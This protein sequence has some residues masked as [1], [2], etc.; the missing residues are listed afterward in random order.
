M[1]LAQSSPGKFRDPGA[2]QRSIN[3]DYTPVGCCTTYYLVYVFQ[4][5]LYERGAIGS[6]RLDN[7]YFGDEPISNDEGVVLSGNQHCQRK[8]GTVEGILAS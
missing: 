2:N 5:T 1:L 8:F 7:S 4:S 6:V 3:L